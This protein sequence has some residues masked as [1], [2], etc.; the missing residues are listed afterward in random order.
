MIACTE[1]P[2]RNAARPLVRAMPAPRRSVEPPA[3]RP[4]GV[5]TLAIPS[6]DLDGQARRRREALILLNGYRAGQ[7]SWRELYRTLGLEHGVPTRLLNTIAHVEGP[8]R[9]LPDSLLSY[10]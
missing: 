5:V 2:H 3:L 8:L 4:R 1:T 6:G 7:V 9:R 10:V